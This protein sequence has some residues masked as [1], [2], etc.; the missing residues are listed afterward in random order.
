MRLN[1]C[2]EVTLMERAMLDTKRLIIMLVLSV[3]LV[4]F[5]TQEVVSFTLESLDELGVDDTARYTTDIYVSIAVMSV[6]VSFAYGILLYTASAN[7]G[8]VSWFVETEEE[9]SYH[10]GVTHTEYRSSIGGANKSRNILRRIFNKILQLVSAF[11]TLVGYLVIGTVEES[12]ENKDNEVTLP[13]DVKMVSIDLKQ[14]GRRV[15]TYTT[16]F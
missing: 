14:D 2:A 8:S 16:E 10:T 5:V 4:A 1:Y 15:I 6:F 7:H 13:A 12:Q 3:T 11:F 9:E